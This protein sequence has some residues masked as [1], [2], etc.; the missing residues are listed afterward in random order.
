[1]AIPDYRG[2]P[3]PIFV[4][5]ITCT[6]EE[7]RLVQCDYEFTGTTDHFCSHVNPLD[8]ED[9]AGVRCIQGALYIN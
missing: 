6:G 3:G 1:M 7:E 5:D 8:P 9:A 2:G 4:T